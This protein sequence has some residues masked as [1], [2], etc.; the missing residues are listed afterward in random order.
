MAANDANLKGMRELG[1]LAGEEMLK[2]YG[3]LTA[4]GLSAVAVSSRATM[5]NQNEVNEY[6][7]NKRRK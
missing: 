5:P 1:K 6:K 7:R 2:T 3:P 4:A